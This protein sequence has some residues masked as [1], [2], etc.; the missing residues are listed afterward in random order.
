[1]SRD[2]DKVTADPYDFDAFCHVQYARLVSSMTLYTG[3]RELAREIANEALARAFADWRRVRSMDHPGPWLHRVATNAANSH[4]R[5]MRYETRARE[6][7]S[8]SSQEEAGVS[9]DRLVL[10]E[11]IARL[12]RRQKTALILRYFFDLSVEE[13]AEQMGCADH[14]VK[15]LTGRAISTLRTDMSLR[16]LREDAGAS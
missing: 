11:R 7:L 12:P 8:R 6:R 3:D 1:M 14:T 13:T 4:F 2:D 10:L 15:K 9:T 5:R 16:D